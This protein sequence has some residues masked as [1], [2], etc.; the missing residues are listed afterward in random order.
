MINK[1]HVRYFK[2]FK[3][4]MFDLSDHVVLAG[5]NN[6][7]KTTLLQAIVV[8]S[9]ALQKWRERRG[10][11]SGSQA[12]ERR[13]VPLTRGDFT[14]LPLRLMD[15]LWTDTITALTKEER[16]QGQKPG[17][18]RMLEITLEGRDGE[19]EWKLGFEFR[20]NS[21]EQL[22]VSPAE[23]AVPPAAEQLSVVHVPPFSGIG[24]AETR[25]DRPFQDLLIGQGKA[26]DILRNL[27][28]EVHQR[29]DGDGSKWN[30]I[31]NQVADLFKVDLLPPQYVGV[32][33][34]VCEYERQELDRAP[35]RGR[36][37]LDVASAGSGF[38]QVLLLLGF[39]Y[40]RPATILLLDEPDA[41]LHVI[42]QKQIYDTIRRAATKQNCQVLIATHS[43]ILIDNT[44]P[45]QIL[46]FYGAPHRLAIDTE[47]DQ[48]REALKRLSAMEI[49]L[50]EK[51][52]GV[53]YAEDQTDADLLTAW[54]KVLRH[55]L[56]SWLGGLPLI[57]LMQGR[58]PKDARAHFFA[59]RAVNPAVRGIVL[60][61]GDDRNEPDADVLTDGLLVARWTRYEAE[62]YL[63]H[64][65]ML[66]RFVETRAS[67][68]MAAAGDNY[69]QGKLPPFLY[70]EPNRED[71]YWAT[72][73]ASKTLLPGFFR[74][75]GVELPK[76]E[77]YLIAETMR[78]AELPPE[79]TAKLDVI[80][81]ALG[82]YAPPPTA[83]MDR[84]DE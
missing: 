69:L 57:H 18:P 1:V 81:D 21:S 24:H 22:Y 14:A 84:N 42:L 23:D 45:A 54:A 43:E 16:G 15:H 13:G 68:L 78:E 7:G 80:A 17:E 55:R 56:S 83:A 74:A 32:P 59:L 47:R 12:K 3:D 50:A 72:T 49:L 66:R 70:Q 10:P 58:R 46:S 61:D 52:S 2:R 9:L 73:P 41:H 4:Q 5:P 40:A 63:V 29:G 36:V 25:F 60:L 71:E 38:H 48:V 37:R 82:P 35:R 39:F 51:A 75:A 6:S 77:Y 28:W 27:L 20:Y 44:S 8:W 30:E 79:V 34:I 64:P 33:H 67:P 31:K 19:H 53:L 11:D 62:S 26:G 76:S 65:P